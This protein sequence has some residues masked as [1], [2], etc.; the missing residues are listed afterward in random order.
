MV[1]EGRSVFEEISVDEL[2][3]L[4]NDHGFPLVESDKHHVRFES[5]KLWLK[6]GSIPAARSP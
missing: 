6:S 1:T 2:R 3:F 5:T 4:V